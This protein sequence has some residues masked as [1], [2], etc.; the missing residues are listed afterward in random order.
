MQFISEKK[1]ST[2]S[3][4]S[5]QTTATS[6][7]SETTTIST[8]S[9]EVTATS[10]LS[11]AGGSGQC[12]D[13]KEV[14]CTD[15]TVVVTGGVGGV[16]G[17]IILIQSVVIVVLLLL[18]QNAKTKASKRSQIKQQISCSG[19]Y[20]LFPPYRASTEGEHKMVVT[21]SNEAY[22]VV[23]VREEHEY[24]VMEL[25]QTHIQHSSPACVSHK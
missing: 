20:Y 11:S 6:T 24:E 21:S 4:P 17:L 7:S 15:N 3:T 9:S 8:P 18:Y 12:S 23:S 5:S 10:T 19:K 25:Q 16:M 22:G 14:L 13:V 1:T 2:T